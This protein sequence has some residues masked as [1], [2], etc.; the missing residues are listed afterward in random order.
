MV[1]FLPVPP[2]TIYPISTVP[3]FMGFQVE[4]LPFLGEVCTCIVKFGVKLGMDKAITK[5][6]S[7]NPIVLKFNMH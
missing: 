1:N 2:R 6:K 5:S 4:I 3:E 7:Q